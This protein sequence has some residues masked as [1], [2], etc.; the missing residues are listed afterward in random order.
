MIPNSHIKSYFGPLAKKL[1]K[2]AKAGA[3]LTLTLFVTNKNIG[4]MNMLDFSYK[5]HIC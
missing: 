4:L 2:S 5:M 1:M 3:G